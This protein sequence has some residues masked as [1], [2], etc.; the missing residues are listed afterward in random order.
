MS[1]FVKFIKNSIKHWYILLI[2]GILFVGLAFFSFTRPLDA[3]LTLAILFGATFL[4]AGLL[5]VIFAIVNRKEIDNW[6]WSLISGLLTLIVGKILI[7]Y[8]G[9]TMVTLPLIIGFAM[10]FKSI[11]A[12][13]HSIDLK[14][15]KVADWGY[16]LALGI[17]GTIFS[18]FIIWHPLVGGLAVGIWIGL[19]F[20]TIG[21]YS[22]FLSLKMKNLKKLPGKISGE[23]KEKFEAIQKEIAE[24]TSK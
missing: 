16:L 2:I 7:A 6:G 10:L 11:S 12:I 9:I 17:L 24:A 3:Y 13:G 22:I 18:N 8:P 5:E 1:T 14:K 4:L 19:T 23:L 15:Y 20:L 21:L